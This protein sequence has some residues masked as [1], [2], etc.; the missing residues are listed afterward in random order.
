MDMV[1]LRDPSMRRLQLIRSI[2][3]IGVNSRERRGSMFCFRRS[4]EDRKYK[5]E[6]EITTHTISK[7][8]VDMLV[9]R[10][11]A[12]MSDKP[13]KVDLYRES[14]ISPFCFKLV[15]RRRFLSRYA[16]LEYAYSRE[17]VILEY[18]EGEE[19]HSMPYR[20]LG[21]DIETSVS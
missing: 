1:R 19:Y 8:A 17:N 12:S 5:I 20:I 4:R 2:R 21:S 6:I 18:C 11:T 9:Q 16:A 13:D 3:D 7:M 15:F 14:E 10:L